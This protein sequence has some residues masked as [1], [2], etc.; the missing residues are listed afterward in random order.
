MSRTREKREK[1]G[2]GRRN[3]FYNASDSEWMDTGEG[4]LAVEQDEAFRRKVQGRLSVWREEF[5]KTEPVIR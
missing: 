1:K 5:T 2:M 3:K 4:T